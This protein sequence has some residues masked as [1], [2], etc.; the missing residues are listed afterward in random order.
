MLGAPIVFF[1]GYFAT[2]GAISVAQVRGDPKHSF[3][4][5]NS[6]DQTLFTPSMYSR[7]K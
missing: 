5:R 2:V 4:G 7:E 6:N 3:S 1:F